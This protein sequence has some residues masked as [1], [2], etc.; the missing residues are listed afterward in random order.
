MD[1]D[2][3]DKRRI[4]EHIKGIVDH[5]KGLE[6]VG[7]EIMADKDHELNGMMTEFITSDEHKEFMEM[8]DNMEEYIDILKGYKS[9]KFKVTTTSKHHGLM[10]WKKNYNY[11]YNTEFKHTSF[12]SKN[13]IKNDDWSLI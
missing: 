9:N 5:V 2:L 11:K 8:V 10:D 3:Y 1:K 12:N 6:D 13:N 4:I 7:Y